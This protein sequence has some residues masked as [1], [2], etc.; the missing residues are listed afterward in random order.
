MNAVWLADIVLNSVK[1]IKFEND[2][3]FSISFV[4]ISFW[5][6]LEELRRTVH[7][8]SAISYTNIILNFCQRF[9]RPTETNEFLKA[10]NS[11]NL[12]KKTFLKS[13]LPSIKQDFRNEKENARIVEFSHHFVDVIVMFGFWRKCHHIGSLDSTAVSTLRTIYLDLLEQFSNYGELAQILGKNMQHPLFPYAMLMSQIL[14]KCYEL[15]IVPLQI[16]PE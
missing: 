2:R 15:V 7:V 4:G 6:I 5:K 14:T 16:F 12:R 1:L 3:F 13:I 10:I 8:R 11:L 9:D